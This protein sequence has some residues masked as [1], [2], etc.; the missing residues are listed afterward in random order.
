MKSGSGKHE[1]SPTPD[2][3]KSIST[4]TQTCSPAA[5]A[6]LWMLEGNRSE[7][8]AQALRA[9]FPD[10]EPTALLNAAAD[11]FATVAQADPLVIRGFCLEALREMYRRMVDVGDYAGALKA[12]KELMAY[13]T[14][15]SVPPTDD[16]PPQDAPPA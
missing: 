10:E 15:C 9:K 4:S 13:A 2:P 1:T 7:D 6:I 3:T 14:K 11:H 16:P 8:I 12:L 5:Q